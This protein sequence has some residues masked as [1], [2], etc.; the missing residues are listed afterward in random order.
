MF[1][2]NVPVAEQLVI[3]AEDLRPKIMTPVQQI[4]NTPA[5]QNTRS[6]M[7]TGLFSG[8]TGVGDTYRQSV[9][10]NQ[11]MN[12]LKKS[13]LAV[14][15][16]GGYGAYI[17]AGGVAGGMLGQGLGKLAGGVSPQQQAQNKLDE[18]MKKHPNPKTYEEY[19]ALSS[20]FMTAGMTEMGEKFHEMAQDMKPT[21]NTMSTAMKD[22]RDIAKYQLGCDYNDVECAKKANTVYIETKRQTAGEKGEGEFRIGQSKILNE[23]ETKIYADADEANYQI[24]SIDQSIKMMDDIYTGA[25]GDWLAYG[26]NLASSFGFAEA[27]WAAGEE[28][29]KVNTMKSVMAWVKQTKGA[30]SEKEMK[31]FADASPGL[32]RTRAGNRLILNTMREAAL[33]QRRLEDEY[34]IWA[35][36]NP[37]GGIRQ[38][39]AHKRNWNLTNGIK[40]PTSAEIQAALKPDSSVPTVSTTTKPFIIEVVE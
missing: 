31:L 38:W 29:F 35:E 33:Y 2:P 1:D 21:S 12:S 30:I 24:A 34:G 40:A 8:D 6:N 23:A 10:R 27:D 32:S 19:M 3:N 36:E 4:V 22:K 17:N 20:E 39:R 37:K 9:A 14:A 11:E 25:G 28:Q 16:L 13:S 26:K 18:L 7:T 15:Q 5:T